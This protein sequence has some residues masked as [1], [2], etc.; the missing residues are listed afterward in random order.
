MQY[1][2]SLVREISVSF[3]HTAFSLKLLTM[4]L[5]RK[6]KPEDN[7]LCK[8]SVCVYGGEGKNSED[9]T[10]STNTNDFVKKLKWSI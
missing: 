8:K 4:A 3:E 6:K 2:R 9:L 7:T 10:Y 1:K 5:R